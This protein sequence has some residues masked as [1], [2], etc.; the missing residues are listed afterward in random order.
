MRIA[1]AVWASGLQ[2]T[3]TL[4]AMEIEIDT[5]TGSLS[6]RGFIVGRPVKLVG[7]NHM[8]ISLSGQALHRNQVKQ[9]F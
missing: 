3:I 5:S 4:S 1:I 6:E 2:G 7:D 9:F 8:N